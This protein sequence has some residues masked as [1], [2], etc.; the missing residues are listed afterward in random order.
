METT[1]EDYFQ[2]IRG[3]SGADILNIRFQCP[4]E[5]LRLVYH[6][7]NAVLANSGHEPFGLVGLEA[8]AAGGIVFTG[9]TGEDYAIPLHNAIVLE[10]SD[11]KEI[12]AYIMYLEEHPD[13]KKR[14]R[15]AAREAARRYVWEEV[16]KILIHKLEYQARIQ[17]LLAVPRRTAIP[18]PEPSEHPAAVPVCQ[19]VPV[20]GM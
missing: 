12:E 11:P 6:A 7:S 4:Q 16:V 5:F 1:L 15:R 2:A 3:S 10:T 13:E 18:P 17:G 19:P 14:I 8:M 9:G 20:A